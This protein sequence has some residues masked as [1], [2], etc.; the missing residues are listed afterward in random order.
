M[1]VTNFVVGKESTGVLYYYKMS[2]VIEEKEYT[3]AESS[4]AYIPLHMM[5]GYL[6]DKILAQ[7]RQTLITQLEDLNN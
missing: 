5:Q 3:V 2:V 1:K 6:T 4:E 7:L